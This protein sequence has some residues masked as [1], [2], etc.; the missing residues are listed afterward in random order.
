MSEPLFGQ[1]PVRRAAASVPLRRPQLRPIVVTGVPQKLWICCPKLETVVIHWNGERTV[2]CLRAKEGDYC[3]GCEQ[4]MEVRVQ[5][6]LQVNPVGEKYTVRMLQLTPHAVSKELQL[7][8]L[9]SALYGRQLR[10]WRFPATSRGRMFAEL[11]RDAETSFIPDCKCVYETLCK[12]WNARLRRVEITPP[13]PQ[14][15]SRPDI[16]DVPTE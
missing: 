12:M 8:E 9:G 11:V 6:W 2:P 1:R 5:S 16:F 10:V 7:E 4:N 13:V 15:D 3:A 14:D